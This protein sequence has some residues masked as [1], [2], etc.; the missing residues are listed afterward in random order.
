[1]FIGA[2]V[3]ITR[4]WT[5]LASKKKFSLSLSLSLSLSYTHTEF[6]SAIK[7]NKIMTFV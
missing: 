4:E 1:M 2:L 7:K 3:T 6:Y 5:T